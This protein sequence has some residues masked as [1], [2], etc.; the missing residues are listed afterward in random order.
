VQCDCVITNLG[1][2]TKKCLESEVVPAS[3]ETREAARIAGSLRSDLLSFNDGV[4]G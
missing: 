1:G 2:L 4:Q 3:V